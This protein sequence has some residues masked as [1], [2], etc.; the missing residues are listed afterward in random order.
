MKKK[1]ESVGK[2]I[3]I[4]DRYTK[5]YMQQKYQKH[6]IGTGQVHILQ[7]LYTQEGVSQDFLSKQLIIDKASTTRAINKLEEEQYV[8][9]K[10]S[11]IDKR[12]NLVYLTD[13]ARTI[14][15]DVLSTMYEWTEIITEDFTDT[16][17]ELLLE[18][19]EKVALRAVEYNRCLS[20]TE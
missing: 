1:T 17:R 14:N 10:P 11:E 20:P 2:W 19:L 18:M 15:E 4:I 16:E 6:R 8:I 3:S 7:I 5:M 9:R 13:K 12:I